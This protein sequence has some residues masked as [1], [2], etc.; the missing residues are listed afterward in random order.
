[1]AASDTKPETEAPAAKA[2]GTPAAPPAAGGL[3][4]LAR[5]R[6]EM[7]R[8]FDEM[9]GSRRWPLSWAEDFGRMPLAGGHGLIDVKTDVSETEDAIEIVA[10]MPG[11]AEDEVEIELAGDLLTIK[12]EKKQESEE[13]KKDYYRCERSFGSFQR[14]FAVPESVDRDAV[15]ADFDKGILRVTLPKKPEAKAAAKKIPVGKK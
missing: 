6:G 15:S 10:E 7:D 14:S 3:H 12:G 4:P 11:V 1:M 5:L 8:L 2:A 13:K 9:L